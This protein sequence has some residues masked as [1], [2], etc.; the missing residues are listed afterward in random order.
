VDVVEIKEEQFQDFVAFLS[1]ASGQEPSELK[2][3]YSYAWA[4]RKP[5]YGF[6]L[7]TSGRVVGVIGCIYSKRVVDGSEAEFCNMC[8]WFVDADYRQ[9]SVRLLR[10]VVRQG[11]LTITNF[12]PNRTAAQVCRQF[13]FEVIDELKIVVPLP[14]YALHCQ[15]R[16]EVTI[17]HEPQG[18]R[19]LLS[20][21]DL[22]LF[23]E[24][25]DT[26]EC[27]HVAIK[28]GDET[29]Y[30]LFR[31]DRRRGVPLAVLLF[32]S[33]PELIISALPSLSRWLIKTYQSPFLLAESRILPR[34][35]LLA[36]SIK[37]PRP[38]LYRSKT[39]TPAQID[40]LFSERTR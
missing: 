38:P 4:I 9:H 30:C 3:R 32:G 34:V 39:L 19:R 5:N 2:H 17:E 10:A 29:S 27:S 31:K 28:D 24:L 35:P 25:A 7:V 8:D 26:R 18:I 20:P 13:G 37:D 6:G 21:S 40:P 15:H 33:H 22:A 1:K 16:S 12:S 14:L 11:E 36:V 23:E